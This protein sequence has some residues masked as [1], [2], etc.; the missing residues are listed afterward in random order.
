MAKTMHSPPFSPQPCP[1]ALN[2]SDQIKLRFGCLNLVAAQSAF[3]P[4]GRM[5]KIQSE[6]KHSLYDHSVA[7]PIPPGLQARIPDLLSYVCVYVYV[8]LYVYMCMYMYMYMCMYMYTYMYMTC[9]CR[10]VYVYVHIHTHTYIHIHIQ[11]PA[12]QES[13]LRGPSGWAE[14]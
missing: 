13:E 2:E 5:P 1:H 12:S 4:I 11:I 14:H 3:P 8:Y 10:H 6:I 7:P 9:T